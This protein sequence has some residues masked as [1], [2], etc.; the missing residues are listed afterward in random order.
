MDIC[1]GLLVS[2]SHI[3]SYVFCRICEIHA[4]PL[5][6]KVFGPIEVT[7]LRHHDPITFCEM[8]QSDRIAH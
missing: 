1:R 3:G 6:G 5:L 8:K 7:T 2:S 4:K